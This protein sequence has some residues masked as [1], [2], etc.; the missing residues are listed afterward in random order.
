MYPFLAAD[1]SPN[2]SS[3]VVANIVTHF[4]FSD[5]GKK[6]GTVPKKGTAPSYLF[7]KL[8]ND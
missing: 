5:N 3:A 8:L 7:Q 4:R 1:T 2:L 6:K